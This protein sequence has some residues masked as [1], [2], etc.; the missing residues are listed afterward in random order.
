[1]KKI[2][3]FVLLSLVIVSCT[4]G[5]GIIE[6]TTGSLVKTPPSLLS[7]GVDEDSVFHIS[8]SESVEIKE[9][10]ADE[11][12]IMKNQLGSSFEAPLP[13]FLSPGEKSE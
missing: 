6:D 1:M 7:W 3:L 8:F 9:M 4:P 12:V 10:L 11:Y 5:E 13:F 2:S